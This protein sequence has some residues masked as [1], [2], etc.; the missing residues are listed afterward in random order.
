MRPRP[1]VQ[2]YETSGHW[3]CTGCAR[4]DWEMLHNCSNIPVFVSS[5]ISQ[6]V[7]CMNV[8]NICIKLAGWPAGIWLNIYSNIRSP[9]MSS[10]DIWAVVP[11]LR[12][13]DFRYWL[14]SHSAQPRVLCDSRFGLASRS[15]QPRVLSNAF[16]RFEV[17]AA[18][19]NT[20]MLD[21]A[22]TS[23]IS[24]PHHTQQTYLQLRYT[25]CP[26]ISHR[27]PAN[28]TGESLAI[29]TSMRRIISS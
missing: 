22:T 7:I 4:F 1:R 28:Y 9:N 25:S 24:V 23:M 27:Y 26:S 15:A 11:A 13:C 19:G 21:L 6:L 18:N 17:C 20:Y 8:S 29:S 14:A 3:K 12:H 10:S 5:W 2:N 16:R